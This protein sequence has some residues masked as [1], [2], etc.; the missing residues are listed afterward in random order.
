[1]LNTKA[2]P[3]TTCSNRYY[4]PFPATLQP[5]LTTLH[6]NPVTTKNGPYTTVTTHDLNDLTNTPYPPSRTTLQTLVYPPFN[7]LKQ[8]FKPSYKPR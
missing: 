6:K 2:L 4:T 3:L 7:P 5:D 1:M 8:A